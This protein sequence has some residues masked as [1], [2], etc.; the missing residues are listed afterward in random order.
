M[1]KRISKEIREAV[2]RD[3]NNNVSVEETSKK[4]NISISLIANIRNQY[5][6]SVNENSNIKIQ[7][8]NTFRHKK[9][10]LI[11]NYD[12]AEINGIINDYKNGVNTIDICARH[13]ISDGTLYKILQASNIA[14]DRCK[15]LTK[16][17][18]QTIVQMY[19]DGYLVKYICKKLNVSRSTVERILN[20]NN[21]PKRRPHVQYKITDKDTINSIIDDYLNS[22]L[23]VAEIH[24][25]YGISNT[26][27]YNLLIKNNVPKRTP[28]RKKSNK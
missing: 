22:D 2:I 10:S 21:V 15:R 14:I 4:Y 3:Y 12:D 28:V 20:K 17:Q 1:A 13:N 24:K 9:L 27:L 5:N 11:K 8:N 18:K 7:Y 6:I 16:E 26:A 23:Y 25:K 19:L